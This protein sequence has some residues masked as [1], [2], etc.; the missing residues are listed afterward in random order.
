MWNLPN[1]ELAPT[2]FVASWVPSP[3]E[4]SPQQLEG[5]NLV[6]QESWSYYFNLTVIPPCE[7]WRFHCQDSACNLQVF[8]FILV[9]LVHVE[10]AEYVPHWYQAV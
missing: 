7:D 1:L 10:V 8:Y 2:Q 4:R 3:W 6:S 9:S 5:E